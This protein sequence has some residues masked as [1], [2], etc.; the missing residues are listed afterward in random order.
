MTKLIT[1]LLAFFTLFFLPVLQAQSSDDWVFKNEKSGVKV[2]YR[3]TSGIY[4]LKLITSIQSSLS[5]MIALLTE[6][7][8]YPAWGY[9]VVES[10]QLARQSDM[11][12]VYYSK[13]DFPWPLDDRD[14][15]MHNTM[16]QDP[17]TH[18]ITSVSEAVPQYIP[19]KD[20]V[21]RIKTAK[22]VWNIVPGTGGWLY[23]EY[24]IYS[25]PAGNIPDWLIN[26]ALDVGPRETIQ[27]IRKFV[28]MPQYQT[29]K[30]AYIRE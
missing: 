7:S 3:K 21:V 13:L 2:Y 20:G 23:V 28:S 14:I 29:A 22:T 10:K 1:P 9:K 16:V 30:L 27:N 15:V 25:D 11:D 19:E 12:I 17:V 6:V 8:S 26:M 24:Y 18:R 5:G 4:E